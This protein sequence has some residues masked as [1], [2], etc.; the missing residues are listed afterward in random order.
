MLALNRKNIAIVIKK[1]L[2]L[3]SE[4][5]YLKIDWNKAII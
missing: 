1:C 4:N 5:F 3:Y 2:N